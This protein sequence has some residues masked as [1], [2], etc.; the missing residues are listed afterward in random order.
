MSLEK[1][2]SIDQNF[3][4]LNIVNMIDNILYMNE[5]HKAAFS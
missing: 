3:D 5:L 1:M 2:I 4:G